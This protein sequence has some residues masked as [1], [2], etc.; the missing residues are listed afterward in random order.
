PAGDAAARVGAAAVSLLLQPAVRAVRR[1][2]APPAPA[3]VAVGAPAG[4]RLHQRR[5]DLS[6][7]R[8]DLDEHG[9]RDA[10]LP[11]RAAEHPRR[12]VR[13]RRTRGGGYV[14]AD[15][16]RDDPAD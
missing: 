9:Q 6:G 11:G 14:A 2:A 7:D 4:H 15:P 12:T 3:D 10:L 8:V 1:P 16:A 5:D 13:G